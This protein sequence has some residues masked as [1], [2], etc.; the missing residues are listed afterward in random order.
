MLCKYS[1]P[2][3][4]QRVRKKLKRLTDNTGRGL[5]SSRKQK[6]LE[7]LQL[8]VDGIVS[9]EIT[10]VRVASPLHELQLDSGIWFSQRSVPNEMA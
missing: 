4:L 10:L 9:A 1:K 7:H 6:Q 5:G 2:A 8:H 3:W